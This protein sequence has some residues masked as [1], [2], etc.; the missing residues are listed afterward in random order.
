MEIG[1]F[2]NS[3]D[4]SNFSEF[5]VKNKLLEIFV[6]RFQVTRLKKQEL[7]KLILMLFWAM[8]KDFKDVAVKA[9]S[10]RLDESLNLEKTLNVLI[11]SLYLR[12]IL[13]MIE[14]TRKLVPGELSCKTLLQLIAQ[15]DLEN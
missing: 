7:L 11:V 1:L 13:Q 9:V 2:L 5:A 14:S 6:D 10:E 8:S 12:S 4:F 3:C 15:T